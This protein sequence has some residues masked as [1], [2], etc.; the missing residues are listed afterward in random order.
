MSC[1]ET[2]A[3]ALLCLS[4]LVPR[5][6]SGRGFP[7]DAAPPVARV[8]PVELEAHGDVR[9]DDY[10]W[11]RERTN[12]EVIRYLAD[13]NAYT[14][15]MMAH[16]QRLQ[17]ALYDEIVGRIKETDVSVPYKM[18]D[19]FYCRRFEEGGEYPIYCRKRGSLDAPE[20]IMLDVN[21]MAKGYEFFNVRGFR[22]SSGQNIVAYP[23]DTAGRRIY[24]IHFKNLDDGEALP[25]VIPHVTGNM[26]WAND[27]KTLFYTKQDP[28]TLRPFRVYKHELGAAPSED[29]LVYEETDDTFNCFV[30]KTKSKKYVLIGC[31]Q[32]LSTEYR[33]L[34]ADH[35]DGTFKVI[36]PRR[37]DLEYHVD[38]YGDR[39]YIRTNLDAKNF[40][41]MSTP[42]GATEMENWVEV[43]PHR[44][45]VLLEGMEVFRNYL[46][47]EERKNG[48]VE[49]RVRP[50]SGGEEH[51]IGFDEPAYLAYST[52]NHD[53]ETRVLRYAYESMTTPES[54]YD[55]DM[56]TRG[57]TLLKRE[58]VLGG[59]KPE[60]YRTERL[61]AEAADGAQVPISI[62]YKAGL[63]R[64]G[65]NPLLLYGYGSYGYSLD[66]NF[67]SDRLSLL[68]RGF[69]YAIAHVRG[70]QE[71]GRSW[72]EDGKLL[73][74]KNTFTDFIDCAEYLIGAGYTTPEQLFI[75]GGSAGG[76]LVGAVI[77]MRP[78]LLKGAVARVPWVDVV[79]TMLDD[80]IPLTTAEY[81]EWGNPNDKV[82]YDY[83][84]SYSP[85]DNVEA[86][87]YPNLLVTTS[88]QDSQ[89]QY[90]EPAKWVA[91]LRALKTDSNVL[92]L[93]TKMQAGHGGV[94]G[95]YKR[96]RETAFT[97]AF[98]LDLLGIEK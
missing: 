77:N 10:F 9:V 82:Y 17:D 90:W 84:L 67:A 12:P 56:E 26:A 35:P 30:T 33:F 54:I 23:V 91:K 98:M 74:K 6:A 3:V 68:D 80:S 53:F 59:F 86:K 25:D 92:L 55:Y 2:V 38:H 28:V 94:S 97:Y 72:Y 41:L 31:D 83:M 5:E 39:F 79:T 93:R 15:A 81:D 64:E 61:W 70:G 51:Y 1:T 40:R 63:R 50:W 78:D 16:T 20:E 13:E 11:L 85:Y 87:D 66:A 73:K 36:Q 24:T 4:G 88:L 52:D 37:R 60:N 8:T 32:T 34:D 49:I 22:I 7:T 76:L 18:D 57:R 96:F 44:D 19:Y 14:D 47:L 21:A 43:I 42:V 45:D 27:N 69:V 75:S 58:E 65:G 89:V 29:E 95:R 48:L 62:V 46:V 71:L